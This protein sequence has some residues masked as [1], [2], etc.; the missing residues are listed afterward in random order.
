V[1]VSPSRARDLSGAIGDVAVIIDSVAAP[2]VSC[3]TSYVAVIVVASP[4]IPCVLRGSCEIGL[5]P[6]LGGG[7]KR[8]PSQW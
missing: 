5:A 1:V 7:H 4:N 6:S 3:T 8:L 2:V